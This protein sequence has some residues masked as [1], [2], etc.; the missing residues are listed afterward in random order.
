MDVRAD[1]T[2]GIEVRTNEMTRKNNKNK[3]PKDNTDTATQNHDPP[4]PDNI[5]ETQR[6]KTIG[7]MEQDFC[8]YFGATPTLPKIKK[9]QSKSNKDQRTATNETINDKLNMTEDVRLE[10]LREVY[11][12]LEEIEKLKQESQ[13]LINSFKISKSITENLEINTT[14]QEKEKAEGGL[15]FDFTKT[16]DSNAF[17]LPAYFHKNMQSLQGILPLTIFNR[18]WQQAASDNHVDYRKQDKEI[19]KYR[20]HPYPG[21][22]TQ[23]RFEWNENFDS[24]ISSCR[25]TYKYIS[26]ADALETHKKNVITIFKQQRSWVVAFRYDLTIRKATLAIRNPGESIPNPAL[27]PPGLLDEIYYAARAQNDLN[28]DENPYRKGGPKS[29]RNPYSDIITEPTVYNANY[30]VGQRGGPSKFNKERSNTKTDTP[31]GNYRGKHFNPNYKRTEP[32]KTENEK[33]GNEKK[34]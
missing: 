15:I 4:T 34:A 19:E 9:T 8:S 6:N 24:F 32:N 30:Q 13:E 16:P 18:T 29:G 22:W 14:A 23:S 25:D 7:R 12:R 17:S 28:T 21:E 5:G 10:K 11:T 33:R 20:G 2:T 31:Y 1:E 27:E 26:F 3:N